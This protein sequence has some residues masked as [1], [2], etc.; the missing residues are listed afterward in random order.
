VTISPSSNSITAG[1]NT[2]FTARAIDE[3]GRTMT[4]V[5]INFASD[6]T[7][8][9]TVDAT[10]TNP[11]TGVAT[12]NVT[13]RNQ[14]TAHIQATATSGGVTLNNSATL[15]VIPKISRIDVAPTTATINRGSTQGFTASAFDQD[16]QPLSG[17]TFTWNSSNTNIA[18][19]DSAGLARGAGIGGVT[20]TA[21]APDGSGGT[22]SGTA[23]LNCFCAARHQRDQRRRCSCDRRRR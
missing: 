12:A 17:V 8:V 23:T 14:G 2:Q 9:A 6:N 5:T 7:T 20:I 13:G 11:S 18:T 22:A 4:G 19:I 10:S 1:Q 21:S 16:N 3:Y 15:N